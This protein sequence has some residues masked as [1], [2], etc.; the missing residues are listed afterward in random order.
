MNPTPTRLEIK[1][2]ECPH[3]HQKFALSEAVQRSLADQVQNQV[4]GS[5]A[6]ER[7]RLEEELKKQA[8]EDK[9]KALAL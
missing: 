5:L 7:Q 8:K 9:E 3:C 6:Q 2:I 4:Q 1:D